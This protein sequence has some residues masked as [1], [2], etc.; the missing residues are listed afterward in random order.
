M[1]LMEVHTFNAP[2]HTEKEVINL[3]NSDQGER[4]DHFMI[5][6]F[7]ESQENCLVVTLT[8]LV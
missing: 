8:T 1:F 4:Q 3:L 7:I 6:C 2:F 5:S